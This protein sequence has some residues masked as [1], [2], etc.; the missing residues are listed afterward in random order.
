MEDGGG[1]SNKVQIRVFSNY[2]DSCC[3]VI[4]AVVA[5]PAT[6]TASATVNSLLKLFFSTL[7]T[8]N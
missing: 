2:T 8:T 7:L 6:R 4:L 5:V 1:S 3:A